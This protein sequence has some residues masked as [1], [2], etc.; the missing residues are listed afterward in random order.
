M[1]AKVLLVKR[2]LYAFIASLAIAFTLTVASVPVTSATAHADSGFCGVRVQGPTLI[3]TS[4]P[5]QWA[6]TIRNKCGSGHS[7]KLHFYGNGR[8]SSCRWVAAHAYETWSMA[9]DDGNWAILN[10]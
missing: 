1:A 7:F 4:V 10:C 8:Y 9:F 5:P 6:Y 3:Y 2:T